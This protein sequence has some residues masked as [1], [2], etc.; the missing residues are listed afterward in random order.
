M[1][2]GFE[3]ERVMHELRRRRLTVLASESIAPRMQRI[4][5]GGAD[6]EGFTAPGPADHVKML[7]PGP[8]GEV[9]RDYTPLAFRPEAMGGPEL[10]VDF[11]LHGADGHGGPAASWAAAAEP[12][13][14]MT[15]AGP[16]GSLLPPAEVGRA[17]LV[18]DESA[19]PSVARWLEALDALGDVPTL[20]LFSVEDAGT[21]AY[22]SGYEAGHRE[23]RW[24]S[25]EDRDARVAEALRAAPIDERTLVFLAGEAGALIPLRRY[26][27]R[28]LGLPKEQVEVHGY[29]KRGV[30]ALDHHAP[31]DPGDPDD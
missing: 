22:L 3:R 4:T 2:D 9:M 6:L 27:R 10:V 30:I 26:L 21:A 15:V 19:L 13:D 29:W 31:L 1:G 17:I 5:L 25:G 23:L 11:V 20:G 24:F 8:D 14:E 28:E 12:G 16:R 7:F 18:A